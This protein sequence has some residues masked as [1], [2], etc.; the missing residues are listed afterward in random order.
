MRLSIK[1]KL[2]SIGGA[3]KVLDE[4]GNL[5]YKV[6]GKVFSITKKKK[7]CDVEGNVLYRVRNKFW[8]GWFN[9]Y[10]F[11]DD[12][13]G[14]R[15]AK[16]KLKWGLGKRFYIEGYQDEISVEGNFW[17]WNY[18]INKN[19][20]AV[21]RL[22]KRIDLVDHFMLDIENEEDAPFLVAVVIGIDNIYDKQ[23]EDNN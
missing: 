7:I 16:L 19:G 20:E 17:G 3:S 8:H 2:V 5:K 14:N 18:S 9:R 22:S 21:G 10:A 6:K 15:V 13:E 23:A 11:I 4:E 1:N 12:A